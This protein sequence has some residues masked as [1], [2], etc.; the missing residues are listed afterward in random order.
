MTNCLKR[1]R[2]DS[3]QNALWINDEEATQGD[4]V[5]LEE[6]AIISCNLHCLVSKQGEREVR[7]QAALVTIL[8]GPG[9]VRELGVAGDAQNHS[10]EFTELWSSISK[11]YE[12]GGALR[13]DNATKM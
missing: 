9:E 2:I 8:L 10:V 1:M 7:T 12:L 5:F 3:P 11:C 4:A 6:N 13:N